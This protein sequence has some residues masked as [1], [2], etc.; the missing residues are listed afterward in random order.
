MFNVDYVGV[1][2]DKNKY[3]F[4]VPKNYK[5]INILD[6]PEFT[7][8]F[9]ISNNHYHP[10]EICAEIF[11]NYFLSKMGYNNFNRNLEG[12]RKFLDW[13]RINENLIKN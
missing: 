12:N 3:G 10:N 5:I 9:D 1:Y 13:Y 7:S 4:S 11:S 6:I 2:L 8:M